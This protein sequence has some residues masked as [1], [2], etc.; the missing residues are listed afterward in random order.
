MLLAALATLS[1]SA[2]GAGV[3]SPEDGQPL[4]SE[5]LHGR[6][7]NGLTYYVRHTADPPERAHLR[8]VVGVGSILERQHERGLSHFVEHMA[9]RGTTG[10]PGDHADELLASIGGAAGGLTALAETSF[11][12][13]IPT[14]QPEAVGRAVAILS[15]WAYAISFDPAAVD[16]ER[17][18]VLDEW[19]LKQGADRRRSDQL[20][21]FIVGSPDVSRFDPLGLPEV[22]ES[23][24]PEAL[25]Y[26]F[27][28]WYRPHR[29]AV[30]VVG[31]VDPKATVEQIRHFFT[32]P[33][34]GQSSYPQ[35]AGSPEQVTPFRRPSEEWVSGPRVSVRADAQL[36]ETTVWVIANQATEQLQG[37]AAVRH[38]VATLMFTQ[39]MNFRLTKRRGVE[40]APYRYAAAEAVEPVPGVSVIYLVA[41]V[42]GDGVVPGTDALLVEMQRVLRY[43]FTEAEF[44]HQRRM[45]LHAAKRASREI[46]QRRSD[47]LA[48]A[49]ALHFFTGEWIAGIEQWPRVLQEMSL[50]EVTAL[51]EPW[52]DPANTVVLVSGPELGLSDPDL[53]QTLLNKLEG[54]ATLEA[55]RPESL[56]GGG[57]LLVDLPE[58]GRIVAETALKEI[59]AVRWTLSNGVLVIA[60]QTDFDPD[61]V[62]L[63]ASSPGGRS[64][65]EDDD[66]LAATVAA[67]VIRDSGAGRYDQAAL[68]A[69]LAGKVVAL[70]PYIGD[71][72]E[73]FI[74]SSSPDDLETLFELISL[75]AG[76]RRV[77]PAVAAAAVATLRE[78]VESRPRDSTALLGTA[79][80]SALSQGHLRARPS[81][82]Q[83]VEE[84]SVDQLQAI[85]ADRFQD[86]GDFTFVVVGAFDWDWLRSLA[87]RH[88][89]AL[90]ATGRDEQWRD[91][92]IDPPAGVVDMRVPGSPGERSFT[93]V[94]FAGEL[95]RID[96]ELVPLSVF[97]AILTA[98][99]NHRFRTDLGVYEVLTAANTRRLPDPEYELA[100]TFQH[101]PERADELLEEVF[102]TIEE[103]V[104]LLYSGQVLGNVEQVKET[105]LAHQE[106]QARS[107]LFW[108]ESILEAVTSGS[109]FQAILDSITQMEELTGRRMAAAGQRYLTRDRYMRIVLTPEA[110][111]Q[112]R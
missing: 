68:N 51:A 80:Q 18:V 47:T 27:R 13:D 84:I 89:A 49:Y 112:E 14:E 74:G 88:L 60:K 11:R 1:V 44:E 70:E 19:H 100:I 66:V 91:H 3:Q 97:A 5:V 41:G 103:L 48:N 23:A 85:Y 81:T 32:T 95:Q 35:A 7:G 2:R 31:D 62:V 57:P 73:G 37:V 59:D 105:M 21:A 36:R 67:E 63:A 8:L 76:T 9:F 86:F 38:Q 72:F 94:V 83:H 33:P 34:E 92:R 110:A 75:Y 20:Q 64:L 46:Q 90:P 102:L 106:E 26:F 93:A 45:L 79:I 16:L 40:P 25:R 104:S 54:A 82:L 71:L 61:E 29:M 69:L 96:I 17:N 78:E 109:S 56:P 107:N 101:L 15:E 43:G 55:S 58:P 98:E 6:L 52:R 50:Q 12:I 77:D 108:T 24:T 28:R 65:V 111:D 42:P 53:E 39:M 4:D 30:I 87:S 10:F 22:I 99:L